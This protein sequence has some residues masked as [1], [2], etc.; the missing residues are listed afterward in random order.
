MKSLWSSFAAVLL[1]CAL[2]GA[3]FVWVPVALLVGV[4]KVVLVGQVAPQPPATAALPPGTE[5]APPGV[6]VPC[7]LQHQMQLEHPKLVTGP[8]AP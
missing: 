8:C 6:L 7:Y 5:P 4:V 2:A 3:P 1:V